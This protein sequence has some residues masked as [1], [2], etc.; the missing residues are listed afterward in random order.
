MQGHGAGNGNRNGSG[1]SKERVYALINTTSDPQTQ[2]ATTFT[3]DEIA[4]VKRV[5]DA[6]FETYNAPTGALNGKEVCAITDMQATQLSRVTG[7]RRSVGGSTQTQ[8][9]TN[10]DEDDDDAGGGGTQMQ[11]G[12]AQ[13]LSLMQAETVLKTLVATGWLTR[14]S[15]I[16]GAKSYYVL[17][18]R[19][20]LELKNWLLETY[21][22]PPITGEDGEEEEEAVERVKTCRGCSDVVLSGQRCADKRC[23]VRM[24]DF[25]VAAVM[26]AGAGRSGHVE[27][28]C[29]ECGRS[30][31]GR[32]FVG[33]RAVK[34]IGEKWLNHQGGQRVNGQRNGRNR[35]EEEEVEEQEDED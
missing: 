30:W 18:P 14:P 29:P 20:L 17:S 15:E 35:E 4:F 22:E 13:S 6:M 25:C 23:G 11:G 7:S 34:D 16:P 10:G 19:A 12:T 8:A 31:T 9:A 5:L 32:D 26:R 33:V 27:Q 24:H 28:K 2:L 1:S 21:N 3:A